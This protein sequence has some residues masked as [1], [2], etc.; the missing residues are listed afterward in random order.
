MGYCTR[1]QSIGVVLDLAMAI[2]YSHPP[3]PLSPLSYLFNN[4]IWFKLHDTDRGEPRRLVLSLLSSPLLSHFC[5]LQWLNRNVT[6]K[7]PCQIVGHA[8][9][10][11]T[12]V[13]PTRVRLHPRLRMPM[14]VQDGRAAV[15]NSNLLVYV[16]EAA[17][18]SSLSTQMRL[19]W[20]LVTRS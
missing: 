11:P 17:Y 18:T 10:R 16:W 7:M 8:D 6:W 13:R 12:W 2:P 19:T 20:D 15:D 3:V 4:R 9:G 1:I 14:P 5:T